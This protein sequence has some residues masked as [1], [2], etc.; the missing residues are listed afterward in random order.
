VWEFGAD[1]YK[2]LSAK[3][4]NTVRAIFPLFL[5]LLL[6]LLLFLPLPLFFG[7]LVEEALA[8]HH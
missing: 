2:A 1:R 8:P 6:L 3:D 4:G 7:D 5:L